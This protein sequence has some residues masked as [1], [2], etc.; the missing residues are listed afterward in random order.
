M[1]CRFLF[2]KNEKYLT[3]KLIGDV[4]YSYSNNFSNFIDHVFDNIENQDIIIDLTETKYI[5]STNLGL[6]AKIARLQRKANNKK[7]TIICDQVN[8]NDI[9][10][11]MGFDMV[12]ILVK[13]CDC[14]K[15]S[16]QEVE[17]IKNL[18]DRETATLMLDAHKE[19]ADVNDKNRQ[20]FKDVITYLEEDL[21]R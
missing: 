17:D 1:D 8:I 3:V 18:D 2:N 6:L 5:D 16:F 14:N 10:E 11:S 21:N 20:T 12:F 13:S 19:L 7:V 15:D 4:K 9:L